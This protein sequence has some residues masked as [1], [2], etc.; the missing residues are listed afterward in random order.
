MM[1]DLGMKFSVWQLVKFL[2]SLCGTAILF[3][4]FTAW[5]AGNRG[6]EDWVSTV[7]HGQSTSD[8]RWNWSL[9]DNKIE[10]G[11]SVLLNV[12]VY[13][14]TGR[15][16][17]G[18]V[19]VSFPS[20]TSRTG[21]DT[22]HISPEG[23]V[24]VGSTSGGVDEVNF[25][26]RGDEIFSARNRRM[27]AEH[28]LVEAHNPSWSSSSDRTVRLWITPRQTGRFEVLMRTWLCRNDWSD[29]LRGP[30]N[31]DTED[32]Q[33]YGVRRL[34]IDVG[35]AAKPDLTFDGDPTVNDDPSP[36]EF[37]VG[38]TVTIRANVTNIGSGSAGSSEL[39]YHIG[40]S[41]P[42]RLFDTNRVRSLN[43]NESD[44]ESVT[45]TFTN[46][47]VGIQYFRL[48]A[49]HD[50]RIDELNESNNSVLIGPF[51]VNGVSDYRWS[52]MLS[53]ERIELG[54]S[55]YL[56]V[57]V[58]DVTGRFDHG[59]VSVSFPSL[60][61]RTGS[62]TE[63]ISPEG[64]VTV[65]STSGGVAQV[66]FLERGDEIF[67]ARNRRMDAEHLLVESYNPSWSSSSDR[68]V[69]LWI[70][71]KETGRFEVLMRTWLCRDGWDDCDRRPA[72]PD[73]ED[74]QDYGVKRLTIDVGAAAKPDL[75]FD[76]DPT[77]ND[78]PAPSEFTVG[79]TVTIRANVTNIGSGSAG[80]SELAY[81]IGRS[82]PDRLFDTD[83][84][85]SLNS[86]ESDRESV[87]YTFTNND[88]GIQYF[89]LVADHDSEVDELN[90][91]NNSVLIGP[92]LVNGVSDYRW[93][94]MLSD[95]RI[96]LGDSVY[97][98]VRVHDVT[99]RF[100]HGGVSV[101]FPSLTSRT[102]SDTEHI[103]PE[104][105]VTV[106]ST[107]GGVA[108]VNF[109]E[110]GD[111]IF[112]ARNR[113]MDAEH[114]LVESY[115]PSWS[116][117]SDR[118]VRLWITPRQTGRFE[119]L[120]RTWLCRD[121]W[122]D[123]DRRPASPDAEDQQDYGVKRLTI[124]VGAPAKADLAFDGDPTVNDDPSPS[125]FTVGDTV[126]IRANVTNIGSG[127]A[128]SSE[129]AYHI[130]KSSPD[131][132]FDT[133]RVRSLDPAVT[134]TASMR[135]S[136]TADDVGIQYF[137]LVADHD[138]EV[139]ELNESNNSVLIGPFLVNPVSDYRWSWMLSDE[140]IEL[141]DSVYL[142]MRVHDV[143]GSFDH[144][145]VS[146]SFPSL[147]SRTGSDTEHISPEG[148]VTV[149]S[150]SGGVAQV[151]FLERGDEIFS[152]RNRRM[153]AEHLLVESY[154]PSW[155][156]SSDRTVRLWI[157]PRQTGRL[158]ILMRTWL[159]RD[160]WDDCDRRPASPDA[161]DQ[162]DYGVKRL[163]I[164]VGAAAKPDLTFD[165]D[166]TVN[167]DPAPSEFTVGD[168]VTIRA[169]VTNIGSGSAGSSEL[170]YHIGDPVS[171]RLFDTSR[172]RSLDP[173]VT[174][175]ASVRY[176]F[177]A[178]DIGIQ[179]F[180]LVA[181][182]DSEVDELNESN[183]SVLIGPFLVNP[184]SDY[185]WSW[186]LSD[187]RIEL[188]DSVYLDVRVHD[189]TGRFDHGGV[190]VSFPSLTSR[191][192]SDNEHTSS[193]G[194]VTVGSTSGVVA[195]VNFYEHGSQI[196]SSSDQ[197]IIA[198]HLL[199]ESYNPS[200]SSSSDRTVRLWIAPKETGRFEV[201]MRTW[202]C[203]DG[204]DDCDRRPASP[205][206]EDQQDYGV[207]RLTIDVGAAAK[208]DLAFDGDPTV[209]D[210]PAPSE[211]TVGDTVT[212][213][214]NVTNIGSG[215]AGSSELAYHIGRSSPDRLFDTNRVRS[216][217][218]AVTSTASM[219]YSFTADDV[220]IQ[221]FRLVADH[222]SEVD[223]LNESNNSALIGPFQVNPVSDYRWS[224]IL[225][226]ERVELGDSVYL[227]IRVH[228]VTGS[229][230]HGG[231]SVSFPSLTSRTG[232]DN[233]H[234]SSEGDVTVG[235]T[236]G[237]VAE[238]NFYERGSQIYSSS[239]QP[240]IAEHLL[241]ESYNP[242]WSSSSDRTVRLWIT[243]KETGRFDILMRTW[244]CGDGWDDC[245][246]RPASPDTEDQ[247]DWGVGQLT[248]D[249][250]APA[251]AD[252]VVKDM[253]VNDDPAPSEFTV[254]D[255][256]TIRASVTNIGS[257]SAG[258][259]ELAYH[260]G[261]P[262]HVRLFDTY[263]VRSLDP[264]VTSRASVRYTFTEDDIGTQYFRLV[265]DHGSEVDE[266]NESNNS[267]LIGPFLASLPA[268]L[269][270]LDRPSN[271]RVSRVSNDAVRLEW[272]PTSTESE[273]YKLYVTESESRDNWHITVL[274]TQTS[275]WINNLSS[276]TTYEFAVAAVQGTHESQL[277]SA[278]SAT[279]A[280]RRETNAVVVRSNRES[281]VYWDEEFMG[282]M[283]SRFGYGPPFELK[284]ASATIG[285]HWLDL[286]SMEHM[287]VTSS[288]AWA[289][290]YV[291]TTAPI[292]LNFPEPS[293]RPPV[294]P[295]LAPYNIA[296]RKMVDNRVIIQ[297]ESLLNQQRGFEVEK[298]MTDGKHW[299]LLDQLPKGAS[300]AVVK[301][302][303]AGSKSLYRISAIGEDS[304]R[305]SSRPIQAAATLV[306]LAEGTTDSLKVSVQDMAEKFRDETK[307][308]TIVI[309]ESQLGSGPLTYDP[310][311]YNI[312]VVGRPESE[313][314]LIDLALASFHAAKL[315]PTFHNDGSLTITE[316]GIE[317]GGIIV[318][319]DF[320]ILQVPHPLNPELTATLILGEELYVEQV[321]VSYNFFIGLWNW[322]KDTAY[323]LVTI[324]QILL[325]A[326]L[327]D[328]GRGTS[329]DRPLIPGP[330]SRQ[331][332]DDFHQRVRDLV[333]N[334][335]TNPKT[336][337]AALLNALLEKASHVY[338]CGNYLYVAGYALPEIGSYFIAAPVKGTAAAGKAAARFRAIGFSGNL[339]KTLGGSGAY[340]ER[341]D[342]LIGLTLSSKKGSAHIGPL[343]KV[344][345]EAADTP[346]SNHLK[347]NAALR[348]AEKYVVKKGVLDYNT[349]LVWLQ[350]QIVAV[351]KLYS[352]L[353]LEQSKAILRKVFPRGS[354]VGDYVETVNR[355]SVS[356]QISEL[357]LAAA[358]I[359]AGWE[360]VDIRHGG[361]P[362]ID[363]I[364]KHADRYI[365][366]ETTSGK[367]TIGVDRLLLRRKY[368]KEVYE[369]GGS[370]NDVMYIG[371]SS[372][373]P[374]STFLQE[375]RKQE[376]MWAHIK[377]GKHINN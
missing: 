93:S 25:F 22:E 298:L 166:P 285:Y 186:M 237:G 274:G 341:L 42:D 98:D 292:V 34:T 150:T 125:E 187:E 282:I 371:I 365:A 6:V 5:T 53:D 7:A 361:I 266:Q 120:M 211:F 35:A 139:D 220:G 112:S 130:G 309:G 88:V 185:R 338:E 354:R 107:S 275:V 69:R 315:Q 151:N 87:T 10:L 303:P 45:Y 144:G 156:S 227:D 201:L 38:D 265:A 300:R 147:T 281:A 276:G 268:M 9:S 236:S 291:P 367:F 29:C 356:G 14:V 345:E 355:G 319:A 313:S 327:V 311:N 132:L 253:T 140:R 214:A 286:R 36:S 188:G 135:Y 41:S 16:D 231:V 280:V 128:G 89:R 221:Y 167:D 304:S 68:T 366:V 293:H 124:D 312:V 110:R 204:W 108:Q 73:A 260:I 172:V 175:T 294:T 70:T 330:L 368:M 31:P 100:D 109:L 133:N 86:N 71:P 351:G 129:L 94:W 251:K 27:D 287:A 219:R 310:A 161:E 358:L 152:A 326:I 143:T 91:S 226:D 208:P 322:I 90:E 256:V 142:D 224:W 212:I 127:S 95:E 106:G 137:R 340:G 199:V 284:I 13:D 20:L 255:T 30:S 182:H 264:G 171:I 4:A 270:T 121:G 146:V 269:D 114:L 66:N 272:D 216:L 267:A 271:L 28:L 192:G 342:R 83:R 325:Q 145:G 189:V 1:S 59:G 213:R 75:A 375:L 165:G 318:T 43:S 177:T 244:L 51:L 117:S 360:V 60:T 258:S 232:S 118:T 24:A 64:D 203:R 85:R 243:P 113:R 364:L 217:D 317:C 296:A 55:V 245:D 229:F 331:G 347:A 246:R 202:L 11:D 295:H 252:L 12:R 249:V 328:G 335:F 334:A 47:D 290:V 158:D 49:D 162:Q 200:W 306:V 302:S 374:T 348:A 122:D 353:S 97:L 181:D 77:V 174:S 72:S 78:D 111:E 198:E 350:P 102:G 352:T 141:G 160:G 279:T 168:T 79:D 288:R 218:P 234:T 283:E 48:V 154:N 149:G 184:V 2:M 82:S 344:I 228:D 194:D 206:A 195:E 173:A 233:E 92:F 119:V 263:R 196:Y 343:K 247:Q 238:V 180:R 241:V 339:A 179:Y 19:S 52:W 169:N 346:A 359:K 15:F 376:L 372:S 277:T 257:G 223:E 57:R 26:E 207:K 40:K 307:L 178:D 230:D 301:A 248:I 50:S 3:V 278:I 190:S 321:V 67:S 104:G 333:V 8:Y 33:D 332:I 21:S 336:E 320:G 23:D 176:T 308:K 305:I 164:D 250:G 183:N 96:E 134:S 61:S 261:D 32:Q 76:G 39:A 329:E 157:T 84:V 299:E 215:S 17:H 235:S 209:N 297:W 159:C 123:C 324:V 239:D 56:D 349:L 46:N 163:T 115:N 193:E 316:P 337:G 148:D 74:Q 44:R 259:S 363:I 101:S 116:S 240:I 54:D 242:S 205:D 369:Y 370:N 210:D 262:V 131:R 99:G 136:F 373:R 105:D 65:G 254:G 126:T 197:P 37:T 314:P 138:S 323:G 170:A 62:D 377:I 155:S 103:S 18:G 80:S 191:T 222:D 273:V 58:H 81:H 357:K 63:H 362:E 153:D 289:L 225:S